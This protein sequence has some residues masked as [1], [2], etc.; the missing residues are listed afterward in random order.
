MQKILIQLFIGT[1]LLL[2][3]SEKQ[4]QA[5]EK[6]IDTLPMLITQIQKCS[7]L[8]GTEVHIHK[9]ITHSDTKA[10]KG[11]FL[12]KAFSI[13]LPMSDRKV[14]I[15]LDLTVKAWVDMGSFSSENIKKNKEKIEII[16][17][18]PTITLT[19]TKINHKDIKQHVSFVRSDFSNDELYAYAQK[20]K[21]AAMNDVAQLNIIPKAQANVAQTIIP[22]I[23]QMGYDE[24]D[25]TISF[26]KEFS[27]KD[28][29]QL[30]QMPNDEKIHIP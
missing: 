27:P 25:I 22:M 2:S 5:E 6:D 9:I 10:I 11:S 20:G 18:D 23:K 8:Y 30:I 21:Q 15:P 16:L 12:Q 7:R 24:K 1:L 29:L 3:C 4:T 14:A 26:R 28:I 19:A 13:E 17:P